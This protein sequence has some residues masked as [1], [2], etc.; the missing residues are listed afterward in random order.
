MKDWWSNPLFR[1][2]IIASGLYLVWYILYE[3]FLKV[4]TAFDD[5][6]IDN[7]VYLTKGFLV[8]F[9]YNILEYSDEK[10]QNLVQI[11]DSLGVFVGA[12]CDGIVLLALFTVFIV[13]F[14]GPW[15]HKGWFLPLGL[16]SIHYI[17]VFRIAALAIIIKT[18]PEW[19]DFNHDYTFTIVVYS[20][21][22]FLW[23]VWVNKFSPL[24][25]LKNVE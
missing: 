24:K 9:G 19:L 14:P 4:N 13:S 12:P 6:V 17:N 16:I 8:F 15:K 18:N 3:F 11:E 2:V 5:I 7:L 23:Y 25:S 1:F 10:Y 21:V 20:F 22:F